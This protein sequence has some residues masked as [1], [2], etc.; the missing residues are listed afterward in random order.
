V[1]REAK[2]AG[3]VPQGMWFWK[4]YVFRASR[5]CGASGVKPHDFEHARAV[6]QTEAVRVLNGNRRQYWWWRDRFYCEDDGLSAADVY[7]LAYECERRKERQLERAR[8]VMAT[9]SVPPAPRREVIPREVRLAVLERDSG[10]CVECGSRFDIQYDH[11]IP[12]TLGGA[13]TVANLQL[14]CA[15]RNQAKG[16][17]LSSSSA[18]GDRKSAVCPATVA[19]MSHADASG[20]TCS[21]LRSAF[22]RDTDAVRFLR[23]P[24]TRTAASYET[25]RLSEFGIAA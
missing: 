15:P 5:L 12:V 3:F 23:S 10:C 14:L 2:N 13:S 18:V 7:A 21:D 17:S 25:R 24:R 1:L 6:Q 19:L 22:L 11:I 8:A 4:R 9:D 16:A 20:R